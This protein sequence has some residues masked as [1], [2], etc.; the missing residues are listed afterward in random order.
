M[1]SFEQSYPHITS[2]VENGCFEIGI[3]GYHDDSFIRAMDEGGVIWESAENFETL[4]DALAAASFP[5]RHR[6]IFSRFF[7]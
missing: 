4:D 5:H 6:L 3:K 1:V 7:G 2:W